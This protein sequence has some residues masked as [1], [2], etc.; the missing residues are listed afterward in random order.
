LQLNFE[1]VQDDASAVSALSPLPARDAVG[2]F[3][4]EDRKNQRGDCAVKTLLSI[5]NCV[6]AFM[7]LLPFACPSRSAF[8]QALV[9]E[10]V[11][12]Q[13]I[14]LDTDIG[15]DIDDAFALALALSSNRVQLL[16]ITTAWGDTDLRARLAARLLTQTGHGGISVAAGPK[17][18]IDA[19]R[20]HLRKRDGPPSFPN[21][22]TPGPMPSTLFLTPF[23]KIPVKLR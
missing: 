15:D 8:A 13:K 2:L 4:G 1:T 19:A 11:T 23:A 10:A 6:A 16:G 12:P 9:Q 17:T 18:T 14:I 20:F 3:L 5:V 21:L 22:K 7:I